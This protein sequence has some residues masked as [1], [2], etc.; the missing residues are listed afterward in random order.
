MA[1]IANGARLEWAGYEYA[2]MDYAGETS[3]RG[4]LTK[5]QLLKREG[6]RVVFRCIYAT[7]WS[8]TNFYEPEDFGEL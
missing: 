4:E 5:L 8:D 6:E 3:L 7:A 1:I 2:L